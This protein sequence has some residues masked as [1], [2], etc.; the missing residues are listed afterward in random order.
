MRDHRKA[1]HVCARLVLASLVVLLLPTFAAGQAT[2][3][4]NRAWFNASADHNATNGGGAPVVQSYEIGFY[5]VGASQPFQ[6]VSLGKPTPDGTG[7]INVDLTAIFMGWPVPGTNYIAD[8]A[9]VGPG[10]TSRSA[11]SNSFS[12]T[13]STP[14]TFTLSAASQNVPAAGG[15]LS[16]SVTTASGCPWTGVSNA[17][18]IAVT[19][20]GGPGNG[21]VGFSVA[22]NTAT[23]TRTGTLTVAGQTV[24][25]N[26]AGTAP[27]PCSFTLSPTSQN[28]LAAAGTQ[29][30]SV[31]TTSGC[32]WTAV[33]NAT[34]WLTVTSGSTGTG[35]G[36][37]TYS[38]IQRTSSMSR[39]GTLTIAGQTLTVTQSGNCAFT[40]SS[41]S[42]TAAADGGP[43]S[44]TVTTTSNCGWTG[45]SNATWIT[46]T[47]GSSGMGA[48]TVA[49]TVAANASANP[50][51]GTLTIA[52]QTV[53]VTQA[54]A[55]PGP[56]VAPNGIR[57]TY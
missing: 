42:Q 47:S 3:N 50:R 14:C 56:P 10:G 43:R 16:T 17:S 26:Q 1:R 21:T 23:T 29:T 44:S 55:S 41:T 22:A 39:T 48:G 6:R 8:V 25:I 15:P 2:V 36:S 13:G 18:W 45:V 30:A 52:G 19:G 5:L 57:V 32:S 54:L 12:F 27:V 31:M 4:P 34:S 37:V 51:T 53:T 40:V 20:S 28:V 24:T 33:S 38:W 9:A 46:V 35:S 11:L 7:T 49:F